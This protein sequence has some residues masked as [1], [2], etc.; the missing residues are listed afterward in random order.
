[1]HDLQ[2]FA[3]PLL[4]ERLD[5][6][7][8]DDFLMDVPFVLAYNAGHEMTEK[9]SRRPVHYSVCSGMAS[10]LFL[11]EKEST[12]KTKRQMNTIRDG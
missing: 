9:S 8:L 4:S 11:V 2:N 7:Y 6:Y 3:S 10:Q 12:T 5:W 1:M